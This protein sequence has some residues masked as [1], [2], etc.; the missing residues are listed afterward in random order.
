[1]TSQVGYVFGHSGSGYL[2]L[3]LT[4]RC[5]YFTQVFIRN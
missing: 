5:K 2:A 3:G 1:V 4:T